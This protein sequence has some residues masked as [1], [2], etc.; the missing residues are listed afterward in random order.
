M[1]NITNMALILDIEGLSK[2]NRGILN[3]LHAL[4]LLHHLFTVLQIVG[5]IQNNLFSP[6]RFIINHKKGGNLD[7][8]FCLNP[9]ANH[10]P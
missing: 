8:L 2:L 5:H 9:T 1:K 4:K 7:F 10:S 6:I 3:R